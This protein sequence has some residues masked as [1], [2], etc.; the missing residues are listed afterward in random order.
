MSDRDAI[1]DAELALDAMR[2][3]GM[4]AMLAYQSGGATIEQLS[5]NMV[6]IH[7]ACRRLVSGERQP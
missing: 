2:A 1:S 7:E 3:L 6:A 4:L 5:V